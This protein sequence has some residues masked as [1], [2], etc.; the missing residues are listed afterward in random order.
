MRWEAYRALILGTERSEEMGLFHDLWNL[1]NI[2]DGRS[3]TTT[4]QGGILVG[5]VTGYLYRPGDSNM[6]R[7]HNEIHT[8]RGGN[9]FGSWPYKTPGS[10]SVGES[11]RPLPDVG[12]VKRDLMKKLGDGTGFEDQVTDLHLRSGKIER[13]EIN[14]RN[15]CG[16]GEFY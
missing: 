10:P 12:G 6:Q 13:N 1:E 2:H 15:P 14:R 3:W 5:L 11:D 9:I 8:G 16:E 4:D 7:R